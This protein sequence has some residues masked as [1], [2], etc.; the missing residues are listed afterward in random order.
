MKHTVLALSVVALFA[1]CASEPVPGAALGQG[2]QVTVAPLTSGTADDPLERQAQEAF[3]NGRYP[4]AQEAFTLAAQT[5]KDPVRRSEHLFYAAESALAA[6]RHYEA[7][8]LY[9]ALIQNFPASPRIPGVIERLFL[10]GRAYAEGVAEKPSL[11]L[12]IEGEDREFGVS[13]L[14][15]FQKARPRHGLADDALHYIAV[16]HE[17][18]EH[19]PDARQTWDRLALDYPNS[20]WAQTALFRAARTY[21]LES[22][23]PAYDTS[24]L[25][26]ALQKLRDYRDRFPVGNHTVEAEAEI[27][28]LEQELGQFGVELARF[29]LRRDQDYS[30]KL[31]LDSVVRDYPETQAASD[32]KDLLSE[33][34]E[35]LVAPPAPPDHIED[36]AQLETLQAPAAPP[37]A[38]LPVD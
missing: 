33:L 3:R 26:T 9:R 34:P 20:E 13:L 18:L 12:G 15:N 29:Y 10:I 25:L 6:K 21:V 31:Y 28:R 38:P 32:A 30:A 19:Y 22:E 27:Q 2:G 16:A 7:Y 4:E 35:G 14:T 17:G 1:G 8:E 11:F 36:D 37:P 5:E 23:G 24:L